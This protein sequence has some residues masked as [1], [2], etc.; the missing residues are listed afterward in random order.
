MD[1]EVEVPEGFKAGLLES[2]KLQDL[3]LSIMESSVG[4]RYSAIT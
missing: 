3:Q 4:L 2:N 1:G